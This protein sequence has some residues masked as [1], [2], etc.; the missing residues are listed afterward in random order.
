MPMYTSDHIQGMPGIPFRGMLTSILPFLAIATPGLVM[1]AVVTNTATI[2]AP[3][4]V[5]EA[6]AGDNTAQDSDTVL[7][8]IV[9]TDDVVSD[10]DGG[11]GTPGVVNVFGGDTLDGVAADPT[12]AVVSVAPGSVVPDGLSFDPT[13]GLVD[14]LPGLAPGEYTFD[15]EICQIDAPDNC[16]TASVTVGVVAPATIIAGT[17]YLDANGDRAIDGGD[18]RLSGWTVEVRDQDGNVLASVVTGPDGS[19]EIAGLPG[20]Q[21]YDIVFRHA[22]T[23][24]VYEVIENVLLEDASTLP[25]QN[26]PIDP[27]GFVYDA[28]TR[29]PVSGATVSFVDRSGNP[30][31][32]D[33]FV[34]ASQQN[35]ITDNAGNYRFDI[36]P[37]AAGACPAGETEYAISIAPPA[38]YSFSSTIL[39]AQPFAL[40]PTGQG[41]PLR[42]DQSISAPASAN[43]VYYLNFRL[44]PGDPDV[45]NNHIPLDPFLSRDQLVVTKTSTRRS[46]STGDLVPYEITVRNSEQFRRGDVDVVDVLPRGLTYVTGSALVNGV[47]QEPELTNGNRELVWRDQIIPANSSVTYQLTLIVG[48]GVVEGQTVNTGLAEDGTGTEISNR[49]TAAVTIVPSTVFDCSELIGQVFVDSNGNGYQDS[50]EEGMPS[51]RLA[52]VKGELITTDE[53]GRYHIACAA[54]PDARIGSNYVLK[55]DE[56]SLPQGWMVTSDNPRTIRLTRGKMGELNFGVVK[57]TGI[58][59]S[60]E[61]ESFGADGQLTQTVRSR[62]EALANEQSAAVNVRATYVID[63]NEAEGL[64]TQRLQVIR[65]ALFDLFDEGRDGAAS[66]IQIEAAA[67]GKPGGE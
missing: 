52:T 45:I 40:D 6:N 59:L 48:S 53:Y 64:V 25:D 8:V 29:A 39:P 37:G 65:A 35:Q 50:G 15:Y 36:I 55:L 38:G 60:F 3:D 31:P 14:V 34:D 12:T 27:S 18:E 66:V 1:A 20:G 46:A 42:V 44:E 10:V 2:T 22:T 30:L 56:A 62:L 51:V 43:P 24:V 58:T 19:Y 26:L 63:G 61:A 54:V 9:A 32:D 21:T 28:V 4:G 67:T 17:V 7:A 41:D 16:E 13:T 47:Q 5:F 23:G 33:C 49:G 57:A 11:T